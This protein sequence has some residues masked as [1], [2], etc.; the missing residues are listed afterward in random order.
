V[1]VIAP[2]IV[3][4]CTVSVSSR[5]QYGGTIKGLQPRRFV[6]PL[7]SRQF[8]PARAFWYLALRALLGAAVLVMFGR[9]AHFLAN[10]PIARCSGV[11]CGNSNSGLIG[12]LLYLLAGVMI[13][14]SIL[15]FRWFSFTLTNHTINI[16]SG[17]FIQSSRV[18]RFDKIQDVEARRDLLHMLL[19]LKSVAIWTASLDQVRGDTRRPDGLI[20]L[21]ADTADWLA[22]FL[23]D[24]DRSRALP[25]DAGRGG[26]QPT[27]RSHPGNLRAVIGFMSVVLLAV[28]AW[29]QWSKSGG[30][31]SA[32]I[33]STA[34]SERAV[35]P[36]LNAAPAPPN[37][38]AQATNSQPAV[39]TY[40]ANM[41]ADPVDY[42]I[43]CSMA[44]GGARGVPACDSMK[45]GQRCERESEF[46]S[47][48]T[49]E[50]T[51]LVIANRSDQ[52][53]KFYW[54]DAS[55]QRT[56]YAV[57]APGR[58][59]GQPSH[60]GAHWLVAANDGRCVGIFNADTARI[61]IF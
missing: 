26:T 42:T 10:S 60:I 59:I 29:A 11:L 4:D 25:E 28:I 3:T 37:A 12:W 14:N 49:S 46:R 36:A 54:L 51:R 13:V 48:P 6:I 30:A 34:P 56:P 8:L 58:K 15:R 22:N 9:F 61:G 44:P 27:G 16:D 50:S 40:A 7:N 41:T 1:H 47:N 23:S 57:L 24:P 21:E 55:G 32:T 52:T 45:W 5:E 20:V 35:A 2:Q 33:A 19:G 31:P 39:Q 17:V 53:L 43:A 18:V 38:P